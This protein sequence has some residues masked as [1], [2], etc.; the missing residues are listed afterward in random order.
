MA[1]RA[2]APRSGMMCG[3]CRPALKPHVKRD[4]HDGADAKSVCEAVR[5]PSVR[6]V[7]VKTPEQQTTLVVH[8]VRDLLRPRGRHGGARPLRCKRGP[9]PPWPWTSPRPPQCACTGPGTACHKMLRQGR[10]KPWDYRLFSLMPSRCRANGWAWPAVLLADGK[11]PGNGVRWPRRKRENRLDARASRSRQSAAKSGEGPDGQQTSPAPL[12]PRDRATDQDRGLRGAAGAAGGGE[13]RGAAAPD[14]LASPQRRGLPRGHRE[15]DPGRKPHLAD[16]EYLRELL[17]AE[18]LEV[19]QETLR[20]TLEGLRSSSWPRPS[21]CAT[22][23][24]ESTWPLSPVSSAAGRRARPT[25]SVLPSPA[26]W[27][28]RS[29]TSSRCRSAPSTI[30][31]STT[32]P[33]RNGGRSEGSIR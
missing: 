14:R 31:R 10:K 27:A 6:F 17:R 32:G 13:P 11:G 1:S 7:P 22:R 21:A 3:R 33:R 5:R 19:D 24:T 25:T 20:D 30:V 12:S 16:Y 4:K 29:A 28:A 9:A 23:R 26:R 8:S 15:K 2:S 18:Y